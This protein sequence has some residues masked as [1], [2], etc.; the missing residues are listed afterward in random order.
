[1]RIFVVTKLLSIN[2]TSVKCGHHFCTVCIVECLNLR[3]VC[4]CCNTPTE[5]NEL[6]HDH[7]FDAIS[8]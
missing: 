6:L 3:H 8:G 1:M 4:P 7:Q 5:P 2:F